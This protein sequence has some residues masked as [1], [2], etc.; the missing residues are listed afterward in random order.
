MASFPLASLL[1]SPL[2]CRI[3]GAAA[4]MCDE[5][6]GGDVWGGWCVGSGAIGGHLLYDAEVLLAQE[7]H[8]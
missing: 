1:A 7:A 2:A 3:R 4:G 8:M 5:K 6:V